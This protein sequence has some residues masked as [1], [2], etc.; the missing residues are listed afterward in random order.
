[1]YDIRFTAKGLQRK[2]KPLTGSHTSS[3]PYLSFGDFSPEQIPDFDVSTELGLLACGKRSPSY[4][5][6]TSSFS[7][8]SHYSAADDRKI[9]FFS[10][11]SG[12]LV[13]S[14]L[15]KAHYNRPITGLCFEATGEITSSHGP[16]TPSLLVCS[17]ASV[18]QWIW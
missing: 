11:N 15:S 12:N 18:D 6:F 4:H 2:P 9:R 10:L 8:T 14:P 1:M 13:P 7:N 3:R 5:S 17:Q 16:Q